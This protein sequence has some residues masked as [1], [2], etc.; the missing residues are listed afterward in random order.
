M[1]L[2]T[3]IGF[4]CAC[5]SFIVF[6]QVD[7]QILVLDEQQQGIQGAVVRVNEFT[8]I[9]DHDGFVEFRN[10]NPGIYELSIQSI[11]YELFRAKINLE[12]PRVDTMLLAPKIYQIETIELN[13]SWIKKDQPFSYE[14][15]RASTIAKRHVGQ[16]VPFL[17][18]WMPAM[19]VTSDAGTG[20]GYTGLRIRGS[21]PT[22]INVT[23]DGVPLNDAE[24]QGVF[25]VDLPDLASS[26][27]AIQVQ[28][29][30]GTSTNGAGAFGG[31]INVKTTSHQA[32]PF[33]KVEGSGGSFGTLRGNLQFGTGTIR[34]H[35]SLQ[36]RFSTLTSNGYIDRSS[37]DLQS[38]NLVARYFSENHSLKLSYYDGKEITYQAW[39]GVPQQYIDDEVLRTFNTA[40]RRR[41]GYHPDE[42]DH[43]RQRH[44]HAIY[45]QKLPSGLL[46]NTT[47]HYTKG[48]GY[49]EQYR[50]G[51]DLPAYNLPLITIRDSVIS[52]SDLIRRRWLDND[53]YGALFSLTH[54]GIGSNRWSFGGGYNEYL[55]DHF[56]EVIWARWFP[57]VEKDHE[58]YRNDARKTDL[59]LYGQ[60]QN[61]LTNSL[62]AF[63]DLQWRQVGYRFLGFDQNLEQLEQMVT[64]HFFNPKLGLTLDRN[65]ISY[66]YSASVAHREPNR[67]D[68]TES[69]PAS[70]P[71]AERLVDHELGL[72]YQGARLSIRANTYY[73]AYR[74]QLTLTGRLNDVGEYGR[75]NVPRSFRSG[76]ESQL[77]WQL[78]SN[79]LF[80][81]N[82]SWSI[83]QIKS[84][85]EA[86]DDWDTGAQILVEHKDV[87][88]SFSPGFVGG[89]TLSYQLLQRDRISV[90][91]N[92][93][94]KYVGSQY[95][96]NTGNDNSKL[97]PYYFSDLHLVSVLRPGWAEE[98]Q[99]KLMVRNLFNQR[100]T[101]N[102]WIYRF[103]SAG[104]DPT[105]DD[106]HA[107][108]ETENT[109][110]LKGL[111]PQA[112][113][114]WMLGITL[115]F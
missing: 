52:T 27:A 58:Y 106:P 68:Y 22:R 54:E 10:L 20:I 80:S 71:K 47:L 13:A 3:T 86:I 82:L 4:W 77:D 65:N 2:R 23:I 108:L 34:D 26:V 28:R 73:M 62:T 38:L 101:N 56:G 111:Y 112:G 109:Y 103:Q 6:G 93:L 90:Q 60:Y 61:Q 55:G 40:G 95:L 83:N 63:V 48:R 51:D 74:D 24:S 97:D 84:F 5:V 53:F 46:L 42:V 113:I 32:A 107:A 96:D 25:W 16:D 21:D 57:G 11:G 8:Q 33:A 91:V 100:V 81:T 14:T 76:F 87:P 19:V 94:H 45:K 15:I 9:S 89:A 92:S 49:F 29:G 78:R 1:L 50:I 36:G 99:V 85:T 35:F 31:T 72:R 39:N 12:G 59:N 37:A 18:R 43:Y 102:G 104:Y 44:L 110:N 7:H 17:L 105:V 79:L 88:L 66:Y 67:T 75:I 41:D 30:V 115:T 64:H 114:N 70:R 69:S 98:I